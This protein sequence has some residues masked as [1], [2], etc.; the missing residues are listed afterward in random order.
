MCFG[1]HIVK[2]MEINKKLQMKKTIHFDSSKPYI[3][4]KRP[5]YWFWLFLTL[6]GIYYMTSEYG[7]RWINLFP[8]S[9][10]FFLCIIDFYQRKKCIIMD[11]EGIQA[12]NETIQWKDIRKCGFKKKWIQSGKSSINILYIRLKDGTE[13]D[14]F[15]EDYKYD[16]EEF[17][18]AFHFYSQKIHLI[19]HQS[20][21]YDFLQILLYL[22]IFFTIALIVISTY[23]SINP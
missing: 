11:T 17:C 18:K 1:N 22:A 21:L 2:R 7:W 12:D 23:Q 15:I 19:P 16:C 3:I 13:K 6:A 14:I 4:R 10:T 9:I 20:K 8:S 5:D